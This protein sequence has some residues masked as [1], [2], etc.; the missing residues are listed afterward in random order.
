MTLQELFKRLSF[1]PFSNIALGGEGDGTIL[2]AKQPAV[3]SAINDAMIRLHARFVL[4]EREVILQQSEIITNYE[5]SSA[6]AVSTAA[7]PAYVIDTVG[8]PFLND[9]IKIMSVYDGQGC[10][11]PLNRE[12]DCH[13]LFTPQVN[14]LQ[15][16]KPI[17]GQPL[18][19]LYQAK[20]VPLALDP[21]SLNAEIVIPTVLEEALMSYVAYKIYNGMNGQEHKAIGAEHLTMYDNQCMEVIDR[22]LVSSSMSLVNTKLEERGFV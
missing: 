11:L 9:I 2:L 21:I 17:E 12:N 10:Q 8:D 16:P 19:V 3:I 22:D 5:I 4:I 13:S 1:G 18:H 20:P 15:V 14:V 6:N 7:D